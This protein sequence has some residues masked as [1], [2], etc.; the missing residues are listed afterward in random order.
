MRC[1]ATIV[2]LLRITIKSLLIIQEIR[3]TFKDD[4]AAEDPEGKKVHEAI[5]YHSLYEGSL[6]STITATGSK[7]RVIH[8]GIGTKQVQLLSEKRTV[9]SYIKSQ[10]H[11]LTSLEID[12]INADG[13]DG[14][15]LQR[16]YMILALKQAYI[17][18]VGHPSTFDYSRLEFDIPNQ[19]VMA[20]S[21]PLIGWE[22]RMWKACF[23]AQGM[24]T[25]EVDR[26]EYQKD[27]S[28]AACW[29]GFDGILEALAASNLRPLH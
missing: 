1:S 9:A 2:L 27:L 4:D 8:V 3:K 19:T 28:Q 11:K 24:V 13:D 5:G 21:F 12:S 17:T 29:I 23:E 15:R 16:L 20:D 7:E 10:A 6:S 18:A 25:G 26:E 22:F 14:L